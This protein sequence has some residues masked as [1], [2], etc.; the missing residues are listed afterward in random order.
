MGGDSLPRTSVGI[1]NERFYMNKINQKFESG[2]NQKLEEDRKSRTIFC[3]INQTRSKHDLKEMLFIS[4]IPKGKESPENLKLTNKLE[5][6][7]AEPDSWSIGVSSLSK[8]VAKSKQKKEMVRSLPMRYQ[9][10]F[11]DVNDP[12]FESD[13]SCDSKDRNE[14]TKHDKSLARHVI[15]QLSPHTLNAILPAS[16]LLPLGY[17]Q[18]DT[19]W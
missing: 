7:S 4:K 3:E 19:V 9:R 1:M 15:L 5:N 12:G 13:N 14:T 8:V 16:H 2:S 18:E 10:F 11:T 17:W 6:H